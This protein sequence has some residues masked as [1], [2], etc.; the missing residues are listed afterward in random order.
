MNELT[1]GNRAIEIQLDNLKGN[2]ALIERDIKNLKQKLK[3][4]IP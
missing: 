4:I 2:I 3:N 1:P